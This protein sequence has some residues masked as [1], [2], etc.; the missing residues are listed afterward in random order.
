MNEARLDLMLAGLAPWQENFGQGMEYRGKDG[1]SWYD[2]SINANSLPCE[3]KVAI[4]VT[5]WQG[6][7]KWLA[8][9][10]ESYRRTG[11]FVILAY[12]NPFYPWMKPTEQD[13]LRSLPNMR[14]YLLANSVVMKHITYDADKRNGWFWSCR[15]AQ[16]ILKQ[17]PNI[18]HVYIT[19]GDC[20][21]ERPEGMPELIQLLGDG[22]MMAG[23]QTE[24][25]FHT[26]E[27]LFKADAFHRVFDRMA[28]VMRVPI[29]GSH[30]PEV[31]LKETID[32]LKIRTVPAP[33]Q[34]LD[35]DGTID[36]YARYGQPSTWRKV[37]GFR[38]LFAEYET[39]GNEGQDVAFLRTF[40]DLSMDCLY[41]SGEERE[42]VCQYWRTGDKRH[43]WKWWDQWED[44]DYN[45]LYYP[46]EHYGKEP[47]YE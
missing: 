5:A 35:K 24:N 38:N 43:L 34:P 26:A 22:E 4:I 8:R 11:A 14:H 42:T 37:L 44:S 32:L 9:T 19:N 6:Q 40:V 39:A 2:L 13:V 28:E 15:Y 20:L 21:V 33:E 36:T 7:L 23:Q 45:R 30:S 47:I 29:L 27:L 41:W 12:D 16:G 18:E 1:M 31:M 17:F 25:A 10:L 3:K 46:L